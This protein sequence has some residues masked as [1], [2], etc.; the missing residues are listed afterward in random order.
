M[1]KTF[2]KELQ[3][4]KFFPYLLNNQDV[5]A[6]YLAGSR[7][8][9]ICDERSDYDIVVLTKDSLAEEESIFKLEYKGVVVHW[10]YRS[11]EQILN[12]WSTQNTRLSYISGVNFLN[13][14]KNLIYTNPEHSNIL[15]FIL[16]YKKD[17]VNYCC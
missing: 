6:I 15:Q 5:V 12:C 14:E 9:H 13:I 2:I 4:S 3:E 1:N 7:S 17:I 8:N 11:L 10:Y 16:D